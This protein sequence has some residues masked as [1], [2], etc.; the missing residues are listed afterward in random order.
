MLCHGNP[1]TLRPHVIIPHILLIKSNPLWHKTWAKPYFCCVLCFSHCRPSLVFSRTVLHRTMS[2]LLWW[3]QGCSA[4]PYLNPEVLPWWLRCGSLPSTT[5]HISVQ[6]L[7]VSLI[8]NFCLGQALAGLPVTVSGSLL[9]SCL[10]IMGQVRLIPRS[11]VWIW[12]IPSLWIECLCPLCYFS[13]LY[14]DFQQV[15]LLDEFSLLSGFRIP[16][17][18]VIY[19]QPVLIG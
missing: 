11:P 8:G 19:V 14:Q 13:K 1:S 16:T 6:L 7:W 12:G 2:L 15:F 17:I 3:A 5:F 4:V 18:L 10:H 9:P